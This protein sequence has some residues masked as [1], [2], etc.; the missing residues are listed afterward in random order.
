[1]L[2]MCLLS[3]GAQPMIRA[4]MS[5]GPP[6]PCRPTRP[7]VVLDRPA[8][9]PERGAHALLAAAELKP[10]S[11]SRVELPSERSPEPPSRQARPLSRA[12]LLPRPIGPSRRSSAA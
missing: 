5:P 7:R 6:M 2:L 4:P 10:R 9:D 12:M 8:G 1:M 3:R 11:G